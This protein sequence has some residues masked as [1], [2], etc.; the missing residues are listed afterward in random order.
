MPTVSH[1][2][3]SIR[4]GELRSVVLAALLFFLLLCSYYVLRPVRDEMAVRLGAQQLKWLFT[5]T[6]VAMLA[7][8]PVFGWLASVLRRAILVPATLG[9]FAL[10]L[11]AFRAALATPDLA[12][13]AAIAFFIWVSVFNLFVV[14]VFWSLMTDL[15]DLAQAERLFGL[16]SVGGTAG[17]IA[18]PALT[19]ALVTHTGVP[20][21]LLLSAA[22]LTLALVPALALAGSAG[23]RGTSAAT[24]RDGRAL[25]GSAWEGFALV[26]RSP[27]LRWLCLFLCLHSFV[28]TVL[29]FE[30]TRIVGAAF[31]SPEARTALFARVDLAVNA[32]T[33]A[34]QLL[35]LAPLLRRFGLSVALCLLPAASAVGLL[36]L[37][38]WPTLAVLVGFGIVRRAG[39]YAIARPAREML[40]TVLPRAARYKAKNFLDTAVFR[41][42]DAASGWLTDGLRALGLA[43]GALAFAALPAALAGTV[44]GWRLGRS[45]AIMSAEHGETSDDRPPDLEEPPPLVARDDRRDPGAGQR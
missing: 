39:E 25:G 27:G 36:A 5:G 43:G 16:V 41:G 42:A 12:L 22:L 8:T 32:L 28:G 14:S 20:G 30:Q 15:F 34:T 17:A 26:W 23:A 4:P 10:N 19:A 3:I 24:A 1:R 45:S 33:L 2:S 7:A 40:F 29:Y 44:I 21:L 11:L 18:G 13:G 35:G 9:F 6:F 31:T 38:L 37:G